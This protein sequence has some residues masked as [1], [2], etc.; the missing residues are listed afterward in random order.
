LDAGKRWSENIRIKLGPREVQ[1]RAFGLVRQEVGGRRG[2]HKGDQ[3]IYWGGP[4]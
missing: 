1:G 3:R 2:K 4:L